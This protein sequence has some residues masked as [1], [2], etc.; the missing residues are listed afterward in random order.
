VPDEVTGGR[1]TVGLRVPDQSVALRLLHEFGGGIA[2]P[3]ANR[4]GRVSPTTAADVRAD[5]GDDVDVILDGGPCEVGVESTIV[6]CTRDEPAVLRMGGIGPE[7]L[8]DVL[9]RRVEVVWHTAGGTPGTLPSHYAPAARVVVVGE[10]RVAE[11]AKAYLAEGKRVGV[12]STKAI[13]GLPADA[14]QL[15]PPGSTREYARL[16]YA[17]LRDADRLG[18]DVLLAVPAWDAGVGH[19]VND[20]LHR[21]A[22]EP[23][24]SAQ[25]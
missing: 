23:G 20:R 9:E 4:F 14:V 16:L 13:D 12:L 11:E 6:D 22:G 5:L 18:L 17:R 7:R 25:I 19:A 3:S 24:I 1:D 2:A 21:A 15:D 10:F 8:E